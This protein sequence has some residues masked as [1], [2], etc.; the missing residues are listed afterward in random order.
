MKKDGES[1]PSMKKII[2]R[3]SERRKIMDK[4]QIISSFASPSVEYR[5][6]PFWS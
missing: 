4:K 1:C 2:S 5:G 3:F 6:K